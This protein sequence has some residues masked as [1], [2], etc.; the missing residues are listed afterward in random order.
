MSESLRKLDVTHFA[1]CETLERT[2]NHIDINIFL[3]DFDKVARGYKR[4]NEL[5][6]NPVT[7]F[8]LA[9]VELNLGRF[10]E[11]FEHYAIRFEAF[12]DLAYIA[13]TAKRYAGEQLAEDTLLVWAEQG[14]GDE[15]LFSYFLEELATRVKNVT[16]A[17]DP[18][19]LEFFKP[20]YPDWIF[21]SRFDLAE[22]LPNT[23]YACPAGDLFVL[24]FEELVEKQYAFTQPLISCP[25]QRLE[26]I[27]RLLPPS[28][29]PRIGISWRGGQGVHGKIRSLDLAA[30]MHG[31]SDDQA[32]EIISLQYDE[33]HEDAV[34]AHGDR[35]IALSGLNN[36]HDL[37]G[38]ISLLSQCDAVITIDNSVAHLAAAIDAPTFVL[39][40]AGQVQF[41]WKNADIKNLCFPNVTLCRQTI[42]GDWSSVTEDAWQRA[43]SV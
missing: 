34:I 31:L 10:T 19:L 25:E 35:R 16:V 40:P 36:R 15:I 43:L 11:G 27:K 7:V 17:L 8:R 28:E 23:D 30:F 4:S 26:E 3:Q 39:I 6:E 21:I 12:P 9:E 13:P 37:Q 14:L 29:K 42:P 1:G 33:G 2:S 32:V 41:R 20:K 18:R 22:S 38:V 5:T 24:F